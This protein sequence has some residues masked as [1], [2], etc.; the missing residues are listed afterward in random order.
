MTQ[1]ATLDAPGPDT[2]ALMA[3][4]L[5]AT[6][7]GG[8]CLLL[9]G[10]VGAGKTHFARALIQSRQH[11]APEDV[12]S[13][14]FTLVQTYLDPTGTE[15]WHADLYR[16]TDPTEL[17]E[18][19]LD[20][21][22]ESAITLIEWPDRLGAP[23]PQALRLSLSDAPAPGAAPADPAPDRSTATTEPAPHSPAL[24]APTPPH[25]T[26]GAPRPTAD[27]APYNPAPDAATSPCPA[28][29]AATPTT[30]L[31][32]PTPAPDTLTPPHPTPGSLTP[33][34]PADR[35]RLSFRWTDPRWDGL[36]RLIRI[37]AFLGAA[38]WAQ[39]QVTPLAGDASARRYLRLSDGPRRA[40]LMD[41]PPPGSL[42]RYVL[43]TGWLRARGFHA[44][45]ILAQDSD[46]GLLLLEDLGDGLMARVLADDPAAAPALYARVTDLLVDLAGHRP[47]AE[48]AALDGPELAAQVGLLNDW[49]APAV[50]APGAAAGVGP[51]IAALWAALCADTPPVT[52]LRDF[53]AENLIVLPGGGLGLLD[54]QDAVAA[55]PA[56]DLASALQD[57]RRDVAPE[58][59]AACLARF[60]AA[61]GAEPER[62]AAAYALM[63]AQ[64]GL[65]I[66]GIFTR[67]CLRDG[68]PR[69][70]AFLP[71]VWAGVA[72]DLAHPALAPL[73][74]AL[75][76]LPPPTAAL[77]ERIA[78]QCARPSP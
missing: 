11:P 43:M 48:L 62:F 33:T 24:D 1:T 9:D 68:K 72:R 58:I 3:R 55:H 46:A 56:Y 53:H 69:Y 4:L 26:P 16:L 8:D 45:E 12:P 54:F 76:D 35:R 20:E 29:G 77:I 59:E 19:G 65:R 74:Q 30:D 37:A 31:A 42:A 75:A 22:L 67:L 5:A 39:A 50:G 66:M 7:R 36:P 23:P 57:A 25:P 2:T 49:Y 71:R 60:A 32:A 52:S 41:D 44:P 70:L 14:T 47:P 64:R 78:A 28:P 34:D 40:V 15:I 17:V 10:P 6:L 63:G 38:G 51:A 21:A 61:T 18:L 73:A 27:P 13:P